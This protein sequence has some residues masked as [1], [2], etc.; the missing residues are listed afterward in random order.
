MNQSRSEQ[1]KAALARKYQRD[2]YSYDPRI[3]GLS[4]TAEERRKL[5]E[6]GAALPDG[7]F[8]IVNCSDAEKAIHAQ[9]RAQDQGK[10]V[11]HIKTRVKALGCSGTIFDNYR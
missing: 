2:R 8:P 11:A 3:D 1:R 10:A 9:G 4:Y 6:S 5:A 7:S